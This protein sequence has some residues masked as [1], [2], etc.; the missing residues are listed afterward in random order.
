MRT[1]KTNV[2][3]Y[4]ELS[5]ESKQNAIQQYR[6]LDRENHHYHEAKETINAFIKNTQIKTGNRRWTDL[7]CM[8]DDDIIEINGLRLRTW[9]INNWDFLWKKKY[10]GHRNFVTKPNYHKRIKIQDFTKHGNGFKAFYYSAI[11]KSNSCVLTGVCW[12][13]DLLQPIYDFI[14]TPDNRNLEELVNDCSETLI[15][16]LE[17]QDEHMD[18]EEYITEHFEINNYEFTENGDIF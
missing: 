14:K 16:S 10:I 8:Y 4:P 9:L 2:Y 3:T 11:Q 1:V 18:T 15:K 7:I 13:N 17:S 5:E 12:D 6:N